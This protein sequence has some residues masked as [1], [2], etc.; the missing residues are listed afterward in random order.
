MGGDD[1]VRESTCAA[2]H[3][4]TER[5]VDKVE[6]NVEKIFEKVDTLDVSL[7]K[8]ITQ[9]EGRQKTN[10]WVQTI[11]FSVINAI[12]GVATVAISLYIAAHPHP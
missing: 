11:I 2:M 1:Y 3:L 7:T 9:T 6:A 10:S 5:R 8:A 4:A 12:V